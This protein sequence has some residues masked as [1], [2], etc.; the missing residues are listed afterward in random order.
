MKN[1][2]FYNF[3]NP[4][5]NKRIIEI[6]QEFNPQPKSI[7]NV[8]STLGRIA[9]GNILTD[10]IYYII[11]INYLYEL[12]LTSREI[13][14][15]RKILKP[16]LIYQ[17]NNITKTASKYDLNGF[18]VPFEGL[19]GYG[20]IVNPY[21]LQKY[22]YDELDINNMN[23]E[24]LQKQVKNAKVT[25]F[26]YEELKKFN[27][28][29]VY[30]KN[31][32]IRKFL[33]KIDN[34]NFYLDTYCNTYELPKFLEERIFKKIQRLE[35]VRND[36]NFNKKRYFYDFNGYTKVVIENS[37]SENN[38]REYNLVANMPKDARFLLF[39]GY[40]SIDISNMAG[41]AIY[42]YFKNSTGKELKL[43]RSFA[44]FRK[45]Y[46]KKFKGFNEKYEQI[47]KLIHLQI[48]FSSNVKAIL[49]YLKEID[50]STLRIDS[51][52]KFVK[53]FVKSI[54]KII[55]EVN[56]DITFEDVLI[57]LIKNIDLIDKFQNELTI[58]ANA[59]GIGKTLNQRKKSLS[60]L[61][62]SI[63]STL[64][65]SIINDIK[66]YVKDPIHYPIRI[67]DEI[68][69]PKMDI[70]IYKIIKKHTNEIIFNKVKILNFNFKI[71]IIKDNKS[72]KTDLINYYENIIQKE[73]LNSINQNLKNNNF[74]KTKYLL[75]NKINN[76]YNK[77]Y[78]KLNYKIIK[79]LLV[80][81]ENKIFKNEILKPKFNEEFLIQKFLYDEIPKIYM[82]FL[83][84]IK[85]F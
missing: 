34:L 42:E 39:D 55:K 7:F 43:F 23:F 57:F 28:K 80:G 29:V 6:L 14:I 31:K 49:S 70:N 9:S 51:L 22:I 1:T 12:G 76:Q 47:L 8:F 21:K 27:L 10:K 40:Y 11:S 77:T 61:F 33:S 65:N 78:Q 38:Q 85:T 45:T 68:L 73:L 17:G 64:M 3:E 52:P 74:E 69:L 67:H 48:L 32:N 30:F 79:Q 58:I 25:N 63:E 15:I 19:R 56:N 54:D 84:K 26:K 44:K 82:N 81:H 4:Q 50:L 18:T 72:V 75:I 13:K 71:N 16:Y 37:I 41:F 83:R 24:E 62:M 66:K 2:Y 46:F 53:S 36:F 5:L 35:K 59:I 20:Y 60:N